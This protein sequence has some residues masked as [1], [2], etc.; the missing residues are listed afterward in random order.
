MSPRHSS[1]LVRRVIDRLAKSRDLTVSLLV[2][3][4]IITL[5]GSVVLYKAIEEPPDFASDQIVASREPAAPRPVDQPSSVPIPSLITPPSPTSPVPA[6]IYRL[7]PDMVPDRSIPA[8]NI[9]V[10]DMA[11]AVPAP[12]PAAGD[13][14]GLTPEAAKD[15]RGL[16]DSWRPPRGSS[17]SREPEFSFTAFVGQYS[18]G[19]WNSTH[20]GSGGKIDAGSLPNL[21][22][23]MTSSS[24]GKVRTNYEDV[25]AIRLDSDEIFVAKPP[26]I[27]L[28]GTRDF[29]LSDREVENVRKYLKMGGAI[30]GDSSVPG[31]NSRF[32]I[33]FR[34][35]M[36]R[37]LAD[38]DKDWE[39]LPESDAVFSRSVFPEVRG[40]PPGLNSYREPIRVLRMYGEI[41]V[42][43]TSNDYGDMWQ[44]GLNR[45]G[46]IDLRRNQAGAYVATNDVVWQN[47]E[48]YLRNLSPESLEASYK[49][50]TN[51][52][53]H[54]LKR[55]DG[56]G[57]SGAGL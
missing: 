2:H 26:F 4:I 27:F 44:V 20:R 17:G 52:V 3:I 42:I 45:E 5:F 16:A 14:R 53:V 32:D 35:E 7:Q 23:F 21:L 39:E 30:W 47:R 13:A 46:K 43:Y 51:L 12:I 57:G 8:V 34:R 38:V 28:T 40:V 19:D 33:S 50:G 25:R 41:S 15:V 1:S 56:V 29:R 18:G 10:R 22:Y 54:L 6:E 24:K 31:K 9:P 55:W 11:R 36:K 48:T 49:F 37:V